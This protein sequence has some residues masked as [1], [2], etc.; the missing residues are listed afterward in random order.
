MQT[1]G[2]PLIAGAPG[3]SSTATSRRPAS[4]TPGIA[5]VPIG[6]ATASNNALTGADPNRARAWKIADLLGGG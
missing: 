2:H 1:T 5:S 3:G 4:H 6:A